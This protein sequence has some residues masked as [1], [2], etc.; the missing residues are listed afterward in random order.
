[1]KAKTL[2]LNTLQARNRNLKKTVIL[3]LPAKLTDAYPVHLGFVETAR[4]C[5]LNIY[6]NSHLRFSRF[7]NQGMVAW[8]CLIKYLKQF[9]EYVD[10]QKIHTMVI[11][12]G[13]TR[14]V[15][16]TEEKN[17]LIMSMF[18]L[19]VSE[20]SVMI[21]T[22]MGGYAVR[23]LDFNLGQIKRSI[24]KLSQEH[25]KKIQQRVKLCQLTQDK[26]VEILYS[27]LFPNRGFYET[28]EYFTIPKVVDD[29]PYTFGNIA[30]PS[31]QHQGPLT[32]KEI[33]T[34]QFNLI[35]PGMRSTQKKASVQIKRQ[36][37]IS[38]EE[39]PKDVPPLNLQ[40]I[41]NKAP[42]PLDSSS[43]SQIQT[44]KRSLLSP[45]LKDRFSVVANATLSLVAFDELIG[46]LEDERTKMDSIY[47]SR[48]DKNK[49]RQ[50]AKFIKSKQ[51]NIDTYPKIFR[52]NPIVVTLVMKD[53]TLGKAKPF[54]VFYLSMR[55][56]DFDEIMFNV[57]LAMRDMA[58]NQKSHSIEISKFIKDCSLCPT[59]IAEA[60]STIKRGG[61]LK[62][63]LKLNLLHQLRKRIEARK[64]IISTRSEG[65]PLVEYLPAPVEDLKPAKERVLNTLA[66]GLF[67][68]S[69]TKF[70]PSISPFNKMQIV[71]FKHAANQAKARNTVLN[72]RNSR[73]SPRKRAVLIN[74]ENLPQ[75][76][77]EFKVKIRG[78]TILVNIVYY[79]EIPQ[80]TLFIRFY[81][82]DFAQ[83]TMVTV[84]SPNE[85]NRICTMI[86]SGSKE[87]QESALGFLINY[88][89]SWTGSM[90]TIIPRRAIV[91][92]S[93]TTTLT[94]DKLMDLLLRDD[95]QRDI[96]LFFD[97][98]SYTLWLT[99]NHY[100]RLAAQCD[101]YYTFREKQA[102]M[103]ISLCSLGHRNVVLK[104][105]LAYD[106][107][108]RHIHPN[109]MEE[110]FDKGLV[111]RKLQDFLGRLSFERATLYSRPLVVA[112]RS[113]SG[114]LT[115]AF[116][117]SCRRGCK[118]FLE[119]CKIQRD[120]VG[121]FAFRLQKTFLIATVFR[122]RSAKQHDVELYCPKT[123]KRFYFE[124]FND[125]LL[126]MDRLIVNKIY[127]LS[128]SE[129]M[130][131]AEASKFDYRT[132]LEAI[133][134]NI[135][136][137]DN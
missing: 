77:L 28:G 86:Q 5:S 33:D 123:Q 54:L 132:L 40:Q 32:F 35:V 4:E 51:T 43:Q 137:S 96:L 104:L 9:I 2:V 38:N 1:M 83:P 56:P 6:L 75:T 69:Q 55:L 111:I 52:L 45:V 62:K 25:I 109:L 133:R 95:S 46:M 65:I 92:R 113:S 64:G 76:P 11:D 112:R 131:L 44:S 116:A 59:M 87:F 124:M 42:L 73:I 20:K 58:D 122:H 101:L 129:I 29:S 91:E 19:L 70:P 3:L 68:L 126:R 115:A 67:R 85:I 50:K 12:F 24:E 39:N 34:P 31:S 16:N 107:I 108:C 117:G 63:S 7:Q 21:R 82:P 10:V 60:V 74:E 30:H 84:T 106:D 120:V 90:P 135:V 66:K 26:S 41:I 134:Q 61:V 8:M 22:Y 72:P 81:N 80:T 48:K 98:A 128:S 99:D 102:C 130:F 110:L 118:N 105:L 36:E 15:N 78:S 94:S 17:R 119:Y 27:R 57:D 125:E 100:G 14:R 47:F 79:K 71:G 88:Q 103:S 13:K 97:K 53:Y 37:S 127:Q 93:K 121:Q 18:L 136:I 23:F 49:Y 114:H 89:R